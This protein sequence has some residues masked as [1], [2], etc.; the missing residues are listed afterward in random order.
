MPSFGDDQQ[1]VDNLDHL[2][3]YL[4]GRS[5]GAIPPGKLAAIGT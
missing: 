2:Y 4:K 1:V 3:A 5:D